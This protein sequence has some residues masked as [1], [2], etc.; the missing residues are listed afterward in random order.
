MKDPC[1]VRLT[2]DD[3]ARGNQDPNVKIAQL[4]AVVEKMGK[5]GEEPRKPDELEPEM[6]F[7][8]KRK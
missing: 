5:T 7:T 4:A 6:K 1:F 2:A 8:A 3:I